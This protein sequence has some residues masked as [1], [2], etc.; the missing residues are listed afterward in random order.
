MTPEA[1]QRC[2]KLIMKHE[3]FRGYVYTDTTGHLTVGYGHNLQTRPISQ[4][5]GSLILDE[6]I[7]W[8]LPKL[9]E[10][11][12]FF[13]D[14]SDERKCVLIDMAYNMGLQGLL[15]FKDMLKACK[16]KRFNDAADE[17]L[18]SKYAE[19]VGQRAYD[20]AYI[21]RTSSML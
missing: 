16:E 5:I 3:N 10:I 20:N 18:K 4:N 19:Q 14:L 1:L 11:I 17:I 2:R 12:D 15:E 13:D 6:D 21:M 9:S 8:F 7:Q